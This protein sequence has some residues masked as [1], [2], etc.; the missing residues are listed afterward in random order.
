MAAIVTHRVGDSV[1]VSEG[2]LGVRTMSKVPVC[3]KCGNTLKG[4]VPKEARVICY[5]C[6][7]PPLS[8]EEETLKY[9]DVPNGT[10]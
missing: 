3:E 9:K 7:N 5:F 10:T 2:D 8:E 6:N 1:M 4:R